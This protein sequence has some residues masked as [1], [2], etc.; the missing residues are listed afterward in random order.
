MHL[1]KHSILTMNL[2]AAVLAVLAL[3][4]S[5]CSKPQ[6]PVVK[7]WDLYQDPFYGFELQYPKGWLV[8][9]EAN[10]IK[11]YSSQEAATWFFDPTSGGKNGVEILFGF[12]NFATAGVTSLDAYATQTKEKLSGIGVISGGQPAELGK[13]QGQEI[14]Y[15]SKI[16]KSVTIYGRRIIAMR[17]SVFYYVNLAGFNEDY[18]LYAAV[19][20]TVLSSIKLPKPK[21]AVTKVDE[22]KPSAEWTKYPGE[23][24]EI[25]YPDNFEYTFPAKKG[26]TTFSM[27]I[28]HKIRQDCA[29]QIDM[30]PAKK[31]TVAKV[32]DQNKGI[33]KPKSTSDTKIDGLDA[34]YLTYAPE[35]KVAGRAYFVVKDDKVYRF[36]VTWYQP[37]AADYEPV[38]EKAISSIKIK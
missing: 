14:I 23:F 32:F 2:F 30:L 27:N 22:S 4:L 18:D 29:I 24:F 11:I 8:N 35:P 33:F 13:E 17:D 12:E 38:F 31:L 7:E 34:K 16:S 6:P 20:D 21:V 10:Q 37:M 5:S 3:M 1:S 9:A 15:S 26:E 25:Q 28:H 19:F 36:V